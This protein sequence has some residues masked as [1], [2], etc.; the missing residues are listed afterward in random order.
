MR[1]GTLAITSRTYTYAALALGVAALATRDHLPPAS[2]GRAWGGILAMAFVSQLFGHTALNAGVRVL[3]ATLVSMFI[4]LE[5]V[6]AAVLAAWLFGERLGLQTG[7]GALLVLAAIALAVRA[8]AEARKSESGVGGDV[9]RRFRG[10]AV[11]LGPG[12]T[13]VHIRDA[14]NATTSARTA[15]EIP[16]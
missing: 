1:H 11:D 10:G 6:I 16:G 12:P 2:D 8:N 15:S 5:P 7:V 14:S 4:L 3:G 9:E 13:L